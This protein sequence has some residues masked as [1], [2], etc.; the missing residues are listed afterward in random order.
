MSSPVGK[1]AV[2]G[3]T[4]GASREHPAAAVITS[5]AQRDR[6]LIARIVAPV[7][8]GGLMAAA[9]LLAIGFVALW[10]AFT[11]RPYAQQAA[12]A[13]EHVNFIPM[14]SEQVQPDRTI[15]VAGGQLSLVGNATK[16]PAGT[17]RVDARGRFLMP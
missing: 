15:L 8:I 5:S 9:R 13:F 17:V 12:V 11:A 4:D 16:L 1:R 6:L 2:E 3:G 7:P 14:D 10:A